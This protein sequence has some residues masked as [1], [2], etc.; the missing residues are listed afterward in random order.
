MDIQDAYGP[1]LEEAIGKLLDMGVSGVNLEDCDKSGK[2]YDVNT[3]VSRI[4]RVLDVAKQRNIPDFVVNARCDVLVRGGALE[5]VLAR[6]ED[7]I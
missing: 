2:M 4:G 5:E 3:A 1:H 6:A 7:S